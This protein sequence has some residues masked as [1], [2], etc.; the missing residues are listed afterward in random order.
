LQN[1]GKLE[2][3]TA[4]EKEWLTNRGKAEKEFYT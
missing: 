3:Y 1:N 4:E 2:A